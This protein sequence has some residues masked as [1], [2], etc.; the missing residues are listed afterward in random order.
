MA[1]AGFGLSFL[2]DSK[3][4]SVPVWNLTQ[5][6]Y[7]FPPE[8]TDLIDDILINS[9]FGGVGQKEIVGESRNIPA[10]GTHYFYDEIKHRR[11]WY[12]NKFHY[13]VLERKT[14]KVNNEEVN[15]YRSYV[16][17]I[18]VGK[19][20][21]I[22]SYFI[23]KLFR[24]N[25]KKVRVISIDTSGP[26]AKTV[27][28]TVKY[29]K[30]EN[31]QQK[32]IDWILKKYKNDENNN[33]KIIICGPRGTGKTFTS[34][35]IKKEYEE[36]NTSHFIKLYNNFDPSNIGVDVNSFILSKASHVSPVIIQIDEIDVIFA[37]ALKQKNLFDSRTLHTRTRKTLL[38]MFDSI[39]DTPNTFMVGTTEKTPEE[40][41]EYED[42][43]S[44]M[45]PGRIDYFVRFDKDPS[46]I[47]FLT[48]DMIENYPKD[49]AKPFVTEK[50][51]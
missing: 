23:K 1:V 31:H 12:S 37:E 48:H 6:Y 15:Y 20:Q 51:N 10:C 29:A 8:L 39:G 3:D 7:L 34:R 42:W 14:K 47:E 36:K 22:L 13:I 49:Q 24:T 18:T 38:Q 45:R 17:G 35:G 25:R 21:E 30:P 19:Q 5:D 43:H 40:L 27:L 28:S 16:G 41:Y 11:G 9:D 50:K 26:N 33:V 2:R 44:F 46:K 4:E 32:V